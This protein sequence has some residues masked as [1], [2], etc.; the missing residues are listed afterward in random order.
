M[1]LTSDEKYKK[2]RERVGGES[3][4]EERGRTKERGR[5]KEGGRT[6]EMEEMEKMEKMGRIGS[7]SCHDINEKHTG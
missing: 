3:G 6:K 5:M 2:G 7:R 4:G 1:V